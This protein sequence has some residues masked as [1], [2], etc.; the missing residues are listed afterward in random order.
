MTWWKN[1]VER[2]SKFN[3]L[4]NDSKY[5]DDNDEAILASDVVVD[6][7]KLQRARWCR[8]VISLAGVIRTSAGSSGGSKSA[9]EARIAANVICRQSLDHLCVYLQ[10]NGQNLVNTAGEETMAASD[11]AKQF[12]VARLLANNTK[13]NKK[14]SAASASADTAQASMISFHDDVDYDLDVMEYEQYQDFGDD[15]D[16]EHEGHDSTPI[17]FPTR[18]FDVI[19]E[20]SKDCHGCLIW[21]AE[22]NGASFRIRDLSKFVAEDMYHRFKLRNFSSFQR[23]LHLHGFVRVSVPLNNVLFKSK[24]SS[25]SSSFSSSFSS[26]LSGKG[27]RVRVHT[28]PATAYTTPGGLTLRVLRSDQYVYS[29][30]QFHQGRRNMVGSI[31]RTALSLESPKMT[32]SSSLSSS[33]SSSSSS[34]SAVKESNTSLML[35]GGNGGNASNSGIRVG[36]KLGST[37][38]HKKRSSSSSSTSAVPLRLV[39]GDDGWFF[40]ND[41]LPPTQ[42]ALRPSHH[43]Q[44]QGVYQNVTPATSATRKRKHTEVG[45]TSASVSS[46]GG[47]GVGAVSSKE[48]AS[49]RMDECVMGSDVATG[50]DND[51]VSHIP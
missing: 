4:Q 48:F 8:L 6:N 22:D 7:R 9:L 16:S 50:D 5:I 14:P 13:N 30:P 20:E 41:L 43:G 24:A 12:T 37:A 3:I 27:S 35:Y 38:S 2:K 10:A 18:L 11:A 19:T 36:E 34:T 44:Q 40:T 42:T 26:S 46:S 17:P 1:N 15:S 32:P 45:K 28:S 23:L 33:S 51:N 31:A 25:S 49:T 29:H 39:F 21:R 47:A